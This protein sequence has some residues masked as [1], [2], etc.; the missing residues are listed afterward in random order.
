MRKVTVLPWGPPAPPIQD[1]TAPGT[2]LEYPSLT[3]ATREGVDRIDMSHE[4]KTPSGIS[5]REL[6]R[7]QEPSPSSLP[8]LAVIGS[9]RAGRAIARAAADAGLAASLAGRRDALAAAEQAEVALLCVP[10]SEIAAACGRIAAAVPPLRYVGHVSGATGLDGLDDAAERGAATFTL[11]PLQTIPDGGAG[12]GGAACAVSGSSPAALDLAR[13]LAER[14]GLTPFEVPEEGRAAYHAAASIASNFLVALG[15]S[16]VE[17]MAEAGIADG[18]ER[19]APLVLRTAASWAE[20]GGGALTGPIAR[21]DEATVERHLRAIE[22]LAPE[23][24]D[25]YR[26]LAERT[27]ELAAREEAGS[28]ASRTAASTEPIPVSP[29]GGGTV[30]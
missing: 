21:G 19:L 20:R 6:E 4:R 27:R 8:P 26:A 2:V 18:R 3:A 30:A 1:D 16:A 17:L 9:G 15:E 23:L 5:M 22:E 14:L 10:D 28:P 24:L 25:T 29:A 7:D 12:L 13:T 11:H